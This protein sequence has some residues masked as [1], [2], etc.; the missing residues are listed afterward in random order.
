M[1]IRFCVDD[2]KVAGKSGVGCTPIVVPKKKLKPDVA[3]LAVK[4]AGI[5]IVNN[6]SLKFSFIRPLFEILDGQNKKA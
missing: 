3:S 2:S 1:G 6:T 4:L 5:K